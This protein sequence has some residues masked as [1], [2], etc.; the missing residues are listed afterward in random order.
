MSASMGR[1][2][3]VAALRA[4]MS[5]TMSSKLATCPRIRNGSV[6]MAAAFLETG[7]D[8]FRLH[9]LGDAVMLSTLSS[10]STLLHPAKWCG[11]VRN[12]AAIKSDHSRFDRACHAH[13]LGKVA[14]EDIGGE[15]IFSIVGARDD[16]GFVLEAI[17]RR[18]RTKDF[19]D[20]HLRIV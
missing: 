1:L 9:E 13:A 18:D 7:G 2:A 15:A 12:Q 10:K 11:R 16:L 4:T 20:G 14:R 6:S 19:L 8:V 17:D 3:R 5:A